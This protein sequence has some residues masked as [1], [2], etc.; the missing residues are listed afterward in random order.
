MKRWILRASVVGA[1]LA[2]GGFIVAASGVI[3][4]KASSGHWAITEWFLRFSM[5]RSI[6]TH[7]LGINVPANLASQNLIVQ[8]ARHYEIGCRSCHGAP[9]LAR[10]RIVRGMLPPPPDLVPRIRES[11][12]QKLFYVVKHGMKFTGMPAWPSQQRDDEVW[13]MVAF[14]LKMPGLDEAGYRRLARVERA[15]AISA[16][17]QGPASSSE[18]ATPLLQSCARCHGD[19]GR[20]TGG[21]AFPKLAGQRSEYF[22][23]ALDAYARA[24]RHSGTMG[25]IAAGLTDGEI[26][27][28]AR[29]YS[30]LGDSAPT[31]RVESTV[32][33]AA[34][35]AAIARGR[36]IATDG[37]PGQRV[38]ACIEC[39]GPGARRGKP[40]YPTLTGQHADYLQLQLQLFKRGQ[41]GGSAYEH[42]MRP[43]AARLTDSQM[44]DAAA[45]FE[46]LETAPKNSGAR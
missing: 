35:H 7:S 21:G 16:H 14:L 26:R 3:S 12:P 19:D 8:G 2:A 13:A 23:N 38:P 15:P 6:A 25:P 29:H 30:S 40:A 22:S 18:I 33:D 37:I 1:I 5:K 9:G 17:T 39:H 41:R 4:I 36:A 46:S 24:A 44:R 20:N 32:A 28:L 34:A 10:P 43:I 27:Q 45:Y 42:L 31:P 11:N